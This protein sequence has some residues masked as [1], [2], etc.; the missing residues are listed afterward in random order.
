MILSII[1][2]RLP[3]GWWRNVELSQVDFSHVHFQYV[4]FQDID[5]RQCTFNEVDFSHCVFL[6]CHLPAADDSLN[7]FREVAC[8]P[9]GLEESVSLDQA[10]VAI[11]EEPSSSAERALKPMDR[12]ARLERE[13]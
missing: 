4:F 3:G 12:F 9:L 5:F 13:W 10:V 11:K 7:H 1:F 6:N 8:I 2:E